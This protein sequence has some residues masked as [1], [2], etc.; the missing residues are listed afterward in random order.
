MIK[1]PAWAKGAVPTERGWVR[2]KEILTLRPHTKEE[3][4]EWYAAQGESEV[5]TPKVEEPQKAV[6][7]KKPRA[8]KVKEVK[9]DAE[10]QGQ[11]LTEAPISNTSIGDMTNTQVEAIEN[12][13]G[14]K[15]DADANKTLTE[16]SKTDE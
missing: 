5:E 9:E 11:L 14:V 16:S 1:R 12:Q 15:V 2:G 6:K 13:Y 7:E 4:A 10:T 8:K 3:I